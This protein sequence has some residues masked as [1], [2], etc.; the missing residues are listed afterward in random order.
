M[1]ELNG[2]RSVLAAKQL[3]SSAGDAVF[4]LDLS[5]GLT[6][7]ADMV[8]VAV[9][10]PLNRKLGKQCFNVGGVT[11][12]EIVAAF[13]PGCNDPAVLSRLATLPPAALIEAPLTRREAV[14]KNPETLKKI[15]I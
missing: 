13:E 1:H 2:L 8:Q 10:G 3:S 5:G 7:P 4:D 15:S 11:S 12:G 9:L 6:N 14:V